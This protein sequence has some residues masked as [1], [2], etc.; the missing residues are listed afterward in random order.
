M[1]VHC[2]VMLTSMNPMAKLVVMQLLMV[3]MVSSMLISCLC[4]CDGFVPFIVSTNSVGV[5]GGLC[6]Y[7]P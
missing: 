2:A 7:V 6:R 4:L 1:L 5:L 3:H